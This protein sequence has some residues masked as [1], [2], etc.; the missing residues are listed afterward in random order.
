MLATIGAASIGELFEPIPE[1]LRVGGAALPAGLSEPEVRARVERLAR[2]NAP[3][4]SG[5]FLGAGCYQ[6]A[7]PAAVRALVGRS[8]FVTAYT[9]YQAEVSQGTLQSIFEFQTAVCELTGLDVANASLYDGHSAC[10]EAAF[11]ACRETRRER[12]VLSGGL[13]PETVDVVR[14]YGSGPGLTVDVT[15]LEPTNGRTS[16]GT[17]GDLSDAAALVVQQPNF[18]GIVE[19]IESLAE[20][21]RAAGALLIVVQNPLTL[22][23]LESPGQLGADIA[24]GDTQVFGT[25]M[26][27]GGPSAGYL[28]CRQKHLRQ[29]P[30]RLVGQTVDADDRISYCLTLQAREQHIRR[31]KATSNICSNQ[32]LC[33]LAATVTLALL[34]PEGLRELGEVCVRRSHYLASRLGELPGVTPLFSGAFFHEFALRLP[35]DA[36]QFARS[37]ARRGIQPGVPLA[38]FKPEWDRLLLVAVTEINTPEALETYLSAAAEVLSKE[39]S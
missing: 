36:A 38:R 15:A 22:G 7:I 37:M 13:H 30:G 27:Y 10:A 8:E 12:I 19:E 16:V 2:K 1:L 28:A 26:S 24:V 11:M 32:A 34:G 23:I 20:V 4:N 6:H 14:T 5:S 18:F 29:I 17:I 31:A 33:A 39:D 9:P 21:A 3:C 35:V 25:P